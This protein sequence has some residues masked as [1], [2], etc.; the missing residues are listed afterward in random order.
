MTAAAAWA[1]ARARSMPAPTGCKGLDQPARVPGSEGF[2]AAAWPQAR[3]LVDSDLLDAMN[4]Y[5]E[6]SNNEPRSGGQPVFSRDRAPEDAVVCG[7]LISVAD[8]LLSA[9]NPQQRIVGLFD[10]AF[11]TSHSRQ[12]Y[13]RVFAHH[14]QSCSERLREIIHSLIRT[15][16]TFGAAPWLYNPGFEPQH[17]PA[18]LEQDW[19]DRYIRPADIPINDRL[20]RRS[21]AIQL[22]R[23]SAKCTDREAAELLG[24]PPDKVP[25]GI[26]D[27]RFSTGSRDAPME[28]RAA[29]VE[30]GGHLRDTASQLVDYQRR[31]DALKDWA[32]PQE[33]WQELTALLPE[34]PGKQ[35]VLDDRKRQIASIYVWTCVTGREHIF[36]P[37]PIEQAQPEPT[38]Q[39]WATAAQQPGT[40][41]SAQ[42][43]DRTT[44]R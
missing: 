14:E 42:A 31:R 41:S 5:F 16:P 30:L 21:A 3:H 7:T 19:Y 38:R 20:L 36:A 11:R 2:V 28:F 12:R 33:T 25:T 9:D 35:P 6:R 1:P 29:V 18:F 8:A 10:A 34:T 44:P 27:D 23:C 24:I 4:A 40:T 13:A 15:F 22:V 39:E 37:R 43:P 26:D 17:I 32:L